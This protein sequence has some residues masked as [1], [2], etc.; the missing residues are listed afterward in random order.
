MDRT[1]LYTITSSQPALL[2]RIGQFLSAHRVAWEAG[3]TFVKFPRATA[4]GDAAAETL[5]AAGLR[6]L[7]NID[8]FTP[9]SMANF[10][11]RVRPL[12]EEEARARA[13]HDCGHD[14]APGEA[15]G[16]DHTHDHDH[17]HGH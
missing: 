12:V 15:C 11:E 2:L 14:H 7:P 9:E 16:H 1:K 3:S 10:A 5:K 8:V 6:P 4:E 17:K 13:A